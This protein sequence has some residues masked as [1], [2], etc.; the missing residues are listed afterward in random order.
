MLRPTVAAGF[1]RALLD[2]AVEMGANRQ[3]LAERSGID[4]EDL[5]DQ[6]NRIGLSNYMALM[7]AGKELAN[8][9]ALA[10]HFGEAY[11]AAELSI[12]GLMAYGCETAAD[13]FA[14]LG[15]YSRLMTDV[16]L[17]GEAGSRHL[18]TREEGR[19]CLVDT[20]KDPNAFP[21]LT[22]TGFARLV[23]TGR[24][25]PG[26]MAFLREVH[27]TH[28]APAYRAEYDRIFQVPVVFESDRNAL[29]LSDDDSWLTQKIARQSRY[30]FGVLNQRAEA[31][32]EELE[33]STST[34]GRVE[35][36]LMPIL[37]TGDAKMDRIAEQ[38]G[39]SRPTLFRKL[40]A[41]GVTFE[42]ILDE[43]R[44]RMALSYLDGRTVSVNETAFLVG[45]SEAASFSRAFKR[46]TGLSPRAMQKRS[47]AEA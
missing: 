35:S 40:R 20:R 27:V 5:E 3:V 39:L 1:A 45:F 34:R 22:E 18:L 13:A 4:I 9:P 10:L 2:L 26:E 25:M 23:S 14:Q 21:E 7:R 46:W 36:L 30:V 31:L 47:A 29:V 24:R 43:F 37:H 16:E 17:V 44:H 15:R 8:E 28:P 33:T 12:V 41:E 32:L 11:D 42:R 6:D 38:M 19:I